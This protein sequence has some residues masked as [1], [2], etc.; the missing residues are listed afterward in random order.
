MKALCFFEHGGID[1][2][3]FGTDIPTPEPRAGEV[4]VQIRAAALNHLDFWV[5][6]GS[7]AYPVKLP[8]ISGCEASGVVESVGEGVSLYKQGD[9]VIIPPGQPCGTCRFC[10]L[11]LDNS[12]E[13]WKMFGAHIPGGFA[14]YAV[15]PEKYL[16]PKPDTVSFEKAAAFPLS[17]LTAWH[18]LITQAQ[19]KA[20][21]TV[22]IVGAGSGIGA[23]GIQIA[24]HAGAHV[25]AG[26]SSMAKQAACLKVGADVVVDTSKP[27]FSNQV[28]ELAGGRGV[29]VVFEHVGPVT[30]DQSLKS[31]DKN[32]RLAICGVTTGPVAPLD[33]RYLFS[34]QIRVIGSMLGTHQEMELVTRL[35]AEGILDPVI[36]EIWP[37]SRG[38]E[39]FA[40][41]ERKEHMGKLVLR[42]DS[43]ETS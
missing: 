20:G 11:G 24:K 28:R 1:K 14:E 8:H 10:R 2:L 33:I 41:M 21:E 27:D 29:D 12:C 30:F 26:T 39:A 25:I 6:L 15:V 19:L 34:R 13:N 7:P 18:L 3:R 38:R 16:L 9:E 40:V 22:F 32:G 42:M 36:F 35:V 4:R 5:L 17:Y 31:L 43:A 37:L 23:A